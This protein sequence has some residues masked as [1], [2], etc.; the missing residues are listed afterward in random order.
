MIIKIP[1]HPS[2]K[3]RFGETPP[4]KDKIID[5]YRSFVKKIRHVYPHA[6]IIC[7]LGSM[8]IMKEGSPYPAYVEKAVA[9]LNDKRIYTHFFPYTKKGG[10][11]RVN[12][13]AQMAKSLIDFIEE[14]IW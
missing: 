3:L 12:E 11:P 14:N 10:H 13:N 9:S 5:S 1:Q 4:N 2:F 7:A 8:D 6:H